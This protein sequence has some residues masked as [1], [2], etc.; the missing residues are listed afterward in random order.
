M[1][2]DRA[3]IER[4]LRSPHPRAVARRGDPDTSWAAAASLP[5]AILRASQREVLSILE[6]YGPMTDEQLVEWTAG[7]QSPSGTRTRRRELTDLGLVIDTGKR[8]VTKAGRRSIVWAA[9]LAELT[10]WR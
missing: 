9:R 8:H 10:L 6:R 4:E 1:S 5:P 2:A 3:Q 7:R